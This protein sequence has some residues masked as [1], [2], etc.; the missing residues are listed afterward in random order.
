MKQP[1]LLSKK[2]V[3]RPFSLKDAEDVKRLAGDPKVSE[4]TLNIPY[5][6]TLQMAEDWIKSHS[7]M[8]VKRK[9]LVYAIEDKQTQALIGTVS[10][11]ST[12]SNKAELG[13]WIGHSYWGKG[14]CTEA[15]GLLTDMIK[16]DFGINYLYAEHLASNPASGKVMIKNGMRYV[17]SIMSKDRH[18]VEVQV[19]TYELD[20]T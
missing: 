19:E 17:G 8:Y 1:T 15:V 4:T 9:G 5:P 6:Y 7:E 18:E 20:L 14:Y 2:I 11:A 16:N 13:Y 10:I 3:L 12:E